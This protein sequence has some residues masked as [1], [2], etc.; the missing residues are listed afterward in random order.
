VNSKRRRHRSEQIICKLP[1]GKSLQAAG[2]KLDEVCR[3]PGVTPSTWHRWV[4]QYG[5]M[6]A[7][8]PNAR[9][10]SGGGNPRV[11]KLVAKQALDIDMLQKVIDGEF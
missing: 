11:T 4:A 3:T 1:E 8:T 6:K 10:N 9:T 2:Q 7:T 5:A